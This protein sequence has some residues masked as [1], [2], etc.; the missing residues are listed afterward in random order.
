MIDFQLIRIKN[1]SSSI[2]FDFNKKSNEIKVMDIMLLP[3]K[4][5]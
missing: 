3:L 2:I 4:D 1:T 5:F